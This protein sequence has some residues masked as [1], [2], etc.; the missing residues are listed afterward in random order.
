M[1]VGLVLRD[2]R[3][4]VIR[5]E[6]D[7]VELARALPEFDDSNF[8]YLR[9]VDPYGDTIFSGYQLEHAVL[10]EIEAL[11]ARR[12]SESMS[13]LLEM[14]RHAASDVHTYLVFVGD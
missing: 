10:A 7:S 3:C 14:A 2:E 8:P 1:G 13:L 11:A 12:P 5:R 6:P 9:L 4:G